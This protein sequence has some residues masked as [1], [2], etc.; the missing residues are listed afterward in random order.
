SEDAV[1]G[2]LA[3]KHRVKAL[4]TVRR[5]IDDLMFAR[6]L[7]F[8]PT[9]LVQR[10]SYPRPGSDQASALDDGKHLS[11]GFNQVASFLRGCEHVV[12]IAV[13][14]VVRRADHA[15]VLPRLDEHTATVDGFDHDR[16]V[17]QTPVEVQM[18][19]F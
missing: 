8:V 18:Y 6:K 16:R 19:P 7:V 3:A 17:A 10:R 4:C 1:A 13:V 11:N 9:P 14:V 5:V 15:G 12:E 2:Q